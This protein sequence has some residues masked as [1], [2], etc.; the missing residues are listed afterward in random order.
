MS[1][2]IVM[3][4]RFCDVQFL[5]SL[6]QSVFRKFDFSWSEIVKLAP[7]ALWEMCTKRSHNL[8][9]FCN[10]IGIETTRS[11]LHHILV[12]ARDKIRSMW[13]KEREPPAPMLHLYLLALPFSFSTSFISL[14]FP[15]QR[16]SFLPFFLYKG[17]PFSHFSFS[18]SLISPISLL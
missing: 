4:Q 6:N 10:Y 13:L 14:I 9:H 18:K 5:E 1:I 12:I 2:L 7:K 17:F 8:E 3:I 15:F 11:S 16:L